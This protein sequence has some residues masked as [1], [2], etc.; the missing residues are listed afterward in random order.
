M[1]VEIYFP[2]DD[3]KK[4]IWYCRTRKYDRKLE[5]EISDIYRASLIVGSMTS[6]PEAAFRKLNS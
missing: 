1:S 4:L 6:A 2:S 5:E 3:W